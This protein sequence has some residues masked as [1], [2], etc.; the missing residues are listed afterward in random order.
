MGKIAKTET[1]ILCD[2]IREEI[3]NKRSLMGIYP[4]KVVVKRVAITLPKICLY[5]GLAG[6][7]RKFE[8]INVTLKLPKLMP[9]SFD[10]KQHTCVKLGEDISVGIIVSPFKI[11][12]QGNACFELRLD[13]DKKPSLIYKFRILV[14][15]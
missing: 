6:I 8:K 3:R 14:E 9:H 5:M 11:Q 13:D 15:E 4:D 1:V 12:N 2:D 10:L 7:K